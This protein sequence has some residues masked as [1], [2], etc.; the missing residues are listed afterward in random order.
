MPAPRL[1][2]GD[3]LSEEDNGR[4]RRIAIKSPRCG[5]HKLAL[6]CFS[7]SRRRRERKVSPHKHNLELVVASRLRTGSDRRRVHRVEKELAVWAEVNDCPWRS[8]RRE[9]L[10]NSLAELLVSVRVGS[11]QPIP[12]PF[13]EPLQ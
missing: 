8:V 13:S 2:L 9:Q 12:A 4:R 7:L 6:P 10:P 5:A 11:K 3:W 1:D